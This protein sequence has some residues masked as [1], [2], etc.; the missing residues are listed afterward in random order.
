MIPENSKGSF[1]TSI[2]IY[3]EGVLSEGVMSESSERVISEGV[4]SVHLH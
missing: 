1:E 2:S 4:L 3:G